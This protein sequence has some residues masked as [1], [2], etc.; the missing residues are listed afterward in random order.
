VH[1]PRRDSDQEI[2]ERQLEQD[3]DEVR[4]RGESRAE[5]GGCDP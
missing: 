3:G 5:S 4:L 1:D 2:R